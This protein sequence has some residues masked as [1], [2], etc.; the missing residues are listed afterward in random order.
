M[1]SA[2]LKEARRA[3]EAEEWEQAKR[4]YE[5][6][7]K[8]L[9]KDL[10][11][12]DDK[13]LLSE[14]SELRSQ[15]LSEA[16]AALLFIDLHEVHEEFERKNSNFFKKLANV[17]KNFF[18]PPKK[19]DRT[20]EGAA[21]KLHE[22]L[23]SHNNL[24]F[25]FIRIFAPKVLPNLAGVNKIVDFAEDIRVWQWVLSVTC[26]NILVD[27][28]LSD[29]ASALPEEEL[30]RLC[31]AAV[32]LDV[33]TDPYLLENGDG[34][35]Q[36]YVVAKCALNNRQTFE[37]FVQLKNDKEMLQKMNRIY[38]MSNLSDFQ[39]KMKSNKS[40]IF[41]LIATMIVFCMIYAFLQSLNENHFWHSFLHQLL[42][43]LGI[44]SFLGVFI[45]IISYVSWRKPKR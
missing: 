38:D 15:Q 27:G 2:D 43:A 36:N 40:D 41:R 18:D 42:F 24:P 44:A 39:L 26:R 14:K 16:D 25:D 28:C 33:Y 12:D 45:C 32:D 11:D 37:L 23:A 22:H 8:Q 30:R 29:E 5:D 4:L 3:L 6:V 1:E 34:G 10:E 7:K 20:P 13:D 31:Q 35:S 17:I 19:N 9:S 21:Q